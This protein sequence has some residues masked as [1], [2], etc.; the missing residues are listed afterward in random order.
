MPTNDQDKTKQGNYLPILLILLVIPIIIL[1]ALA[2]KSYVDQ[3]SAADKK[4]ESSKGQQQT[5]EDDEEEH[6]DG[7]DEK[8]EDQTGEDE[9]AP[10][11]D[12]KI[13]YLT[14]DDG[15]SQYTA[16]ILNI[17]KEHD[18]PA[19]FFMQ[20]INLQQ[21][22]WQ[23]DVK[24][25]SEE[26]HYIGA[27]S[28][29]HNY[30][31]LYGQQQFVPEMEDTLKIIDDLIGTNPRL[32]RAPYGS[33]PGLNGVETR[34]KIVDVDMQLWDWTIDSLD[35]DLANNPQQIVTNIQNEL[36][37]EREVILMHE[38]Q[39]TV[40]VLPQI[41]DMLKEAGYEFVV[42]HPAQHFPVNFQFDE[43]L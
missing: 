6:V 39:Q 10:L 24:R 2:I 18:V 25:A 43:R 1:G 27:H 23:D 13:V 22:Q 20:G 11:P 8:A 4:E 38:K 12:G 9:P 14:F 21:A 29:T 30:Q 16:D 26:G 35:W 5:T 31:A 34:D 7:E 42:Y 19:T 17:L 37:D 32:V 36:S 41:I 33:A 3:A 40:Q 28:M 15:P